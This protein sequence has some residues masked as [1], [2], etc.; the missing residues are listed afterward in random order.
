MHCRLRS[1]ALCD[2]TCLT[3]CTWY[4]YIYEFIVLSGIVAQFDVVP[5]VVHSFFDLF[6]C[7]DYASGTNHTL[8]TY[9]YAKMYSGV[10]TATFQKQITSQELTAEGIANIGPAVAT[11]AAVEGLDAHRNAVLVRLDQLKQ[12]S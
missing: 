1:P 7:G 12:Q 10:N 3:A 6:S 9:G 4:W 11:L 8:P 2:L 5:S